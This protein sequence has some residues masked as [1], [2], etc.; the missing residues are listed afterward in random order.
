[1]RLCLETRQINDER[2]SDENQAW[3]VMLTDD[4]VGET[5]DDRFKIL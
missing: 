1:M 5:E 4:S 2:C 3:S